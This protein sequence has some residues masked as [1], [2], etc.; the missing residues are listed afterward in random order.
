[1]GGDR[2]SHDRLHFKNWIFMWLLCPQGQGEN[3]RRGGMWMQ[4]A[5]HHHHH[6]HKKEYQY[7]CF[8]TALRV[9]SVAAVR[10][11]LLQVYLCDLWV[12]KKVSHWTWGGCVSKHRARLSSRRAGPCMGWKDRAVSNTSKC[13]R[14]CL[15]SRMWCALLRTN[16]A[17]LFLSVR[18]I[19]NSA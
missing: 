13:C 12:S 16:W 10:E 5:P 14:V 15:S 19:I 17:L 9:S 3:P 2:F 1:M 6:H 11:H 8:W 4:I 7:P 18:W